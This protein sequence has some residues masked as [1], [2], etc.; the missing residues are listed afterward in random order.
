MEETFA[1][2]SA[3]DPG[4]KAQFAI[5]KELA[6]VALTVE[7]YA[8]LVAKVPS[9]QW[10][11]YIGRSQV[12]RA[13]W[14][15]QIVNDENSRFKCP[16]CNVWGVLHE[17]CAKLCGVVAEDV[18]LT[19]PAPQ[20]NFMLVSGAGFCDDAWW[21]SVG[22]IAAVGACFEE[23]AGPAAIGD[24]AFEMFRANQGSENQWADVP[25][26]LAVFGFGPRP[27][28]QAATP[29]HSMDDPEADD[30]RGLFGWESAWDEPPAEADT[31]DGGNQQGPNCLPGEVAE[32]DIQLDRRARGETH[33]AATK[34]LPTNMVRQILECREGALKWWFEATKLDEAQAGWRQKAVLLDLF[35]RVGG[36]K[37]VGAG[38]LG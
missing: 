26:A 21:P 19:A 12:P 10:R 33:T 38:G 35:C 17:F 1:K 29:R 23:R 28:G 31:R 3:L 32:A 2:E 5:S 25:A 30:S 13:K 27:R 14:K 37:W 24:R 16:A 18:V 15:K 22:Y 8:L 34:D 11:R 20:K 36:G 9:H 4:W 6:D 7:I